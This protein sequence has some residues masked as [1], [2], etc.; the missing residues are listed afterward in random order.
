LLL[1]I[2]PHLDEAQ[3][4]AVRAWIE[5]AASTLTLVYGRWPR[6][7]WRVEVAPLSRASAS[8]V[9]WGQVLR[10][11]IDTVSFY[12]DSTASQSRLVADWTAYHEFSHLLLPYRGWGDQWF[13]EGLA[14]YYQNVLQVRGGLLSQ[15][16]FWTKLRNGFV[17]GRDNRRPGLS[18]GELS[19]N[20]RESGSFMR[21]YWSGVWYFLKADIELRKQTDNEL[22]LDI[23]LERLNSCCGQE[24]WSARHMVRKLDQVT[25]QSLFVEL[26]EQ[27]A[28]S[29]AIPDFEPLFQ[30]L[31]VQVDGDRAIT[32]LSAP[33]SAV[34]QGISARAPHIASPAN[35]KSSTI[36]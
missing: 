36:N 5:T 16:Q 6:D 32:L 14:S 27:V 8:P 21:V 25:G 30:E 17:R 34:R 35:P 9:P 28:A 15:Q 12:I 26:F 19:D 18:L 2:H 22:S 13:S 11:D 1:E 24:H 31:G 29:R 33:A 23:A 20:M 7:R 3:Q 4:L 10:G